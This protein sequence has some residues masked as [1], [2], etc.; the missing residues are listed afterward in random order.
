MLNNKPMHE[1]CLKSHTYENMENRMDVKF[2]KYILK[3][4]IQ[5]FRH[6]FE[7]SFLCRFAYLH[8]S[9]RFAKEGVLQPVITIHVG[10]V[11]RRVLLLK[12]GIKYVTSSYKIE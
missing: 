10:R 2:P 9:S 6:T 11:E 7:D 3:T 12:A 8:S 5:V 4:D 1:E